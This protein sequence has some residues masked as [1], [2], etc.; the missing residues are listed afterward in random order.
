MTLFFSKSLEK[1]GKIQS[2]IHTRLS[3]SK[4]FVNSH[5][6]FFCVFSIL[7][8]GLLF[9]FPN[10]GKQGLILDEVVYFQWAEH[11]TTSNDFLT[12][13]AYGAESLWI[14]K[15]PL[16]IWLMSLSF[17]IF[18]INNFAARFWS[19]IFGVFSCVLTF[20][21]GKSFYN[22]IVGLLSALILTTFVT[23]F[24]FSRLAT[25]DIPLTFFSL[26]SIYFC[27]L[28]ED[29]KNNKFS[30]LSG[31]FFGL[32]LLTKQ[33]SALVIPIILISYFLL[34]KK[35]IRFLFTKRFTLFWLTG[36]FIF[37]PWL[38]SMYINFGSNFWDNYFVYH[39]FERMTETIEFHS[40]SYFYYFSYLIE[41]EHV[42][43]IF[44]LPF[45]V[46]LCFLGAIRKQMKGDILILVWILA[47]LGIFSF[48]QTKLFWYI[49][50]VFPAF[51]ILLSKFLNA[52]FKK[53][54]FLGII[55]ILTLIV[56]S[57]I[58]PMFAS[59]QNFNPI[60]E[61]NYSVGANGRLTSFAIYNNTN[62][63]SPQMVITGDYYD[64]IRVISQLQI[65]DGKTLEFND[66][67]PWYWTGDT[68]VNSMAIGDVD[69]DGDTEIVTGGDYYNG[70]TV[71]A[72]LLV[73]NAETLELENET[74]WCWTTDTRVNS[75]AIGDVDDDGDTEI[76]T[77]GDYFDGNRVIAQVY[78]WDGGSLKE[79]KVTNWYW[80]SN[81]TVNSIAIGDVDGDATPEIISGGYYNDGTREVAQ[82]I[83]WTPS[84]SV[85]NLTGEYWGTT[86]WWDGN[87][88]INSVAI[89]DVDGDKS[90]EIVTGGFF[91][92]DV[93]NAHIVV[94]NGK[95]LS[96][97]TGTCW[98]W[99]NTR[100][101]SVA[102][103]DVD[104][105]G[106]MEIISGGS[107]FDGKYD[108]AQLSAWS[109]NPMKLKSIYNW[110]SE[111]DTTINSVIT[112]DIDRNEINEIVTGGVYDDNGKIHYQFRVWEM[113][114]K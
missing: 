86:I 112:E 98:N 34:T 26:A 12:P 22:R 7:V 73:W 35:N 39:V 8:I 21:L 113:V 111:C 87:A 24:Q 27:I 81:T 30:I 41:N 25:L 71:Y 16:S 9:F 104:N 83:I 89:G 36:F 61:K 3:H 53:M 105:D 93:K 65:W 92:V 50:P 55:P 11:M 99:N 52:Y 51:A 68:H 66:S 75:V 45:A 17:S 40:E 77:G 5:K 100:I 10:L 19:P 60:Y 88:R 20:Y 43:W 59:Q 80:I 29:S 96:V 62:S 42:F 103:G 46:S 37:V 91:E 78:I 4:S 109:G 38:I 6:D 13:W 63:N 101:N 49:I 58:L 76:V 106:T 74:A 97:K 18:G 84:L 23:F 85:K 110:N 48:A 15:P 28:S 64:G 32:A 14:G 95:D 67:V 56:F 108:N 1:L 102:I 70:T 107:Y 79:E 31:V 54:R 44:L 72:H 47:I 94:W 114:S 2:Q 82:L 69:D 57:M 33:L 90:F